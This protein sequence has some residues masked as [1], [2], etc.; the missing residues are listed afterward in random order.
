MQEQ[1]N[2]YGEQF[3]SN[4]TEPSTYS[5]FNNPREITVDEMKAYVALQIAMGQCCKPELSDYWRKYWLTH[6]KFGEVMSRNRYELISS[7]LHFNDNTE[8]KATDDPLFKVRPL[9]DIIDP[10]YTKHYCPQRE[11]SIDE[12]MI[13]FKGRVFFRQFLPSKPIRFGIK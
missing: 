7:F 8:M 5:V 9:L 3:L 10:L 12:S 11:L 1:S 4:I 6:L 2:L 13:K